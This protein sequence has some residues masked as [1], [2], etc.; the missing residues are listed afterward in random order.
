MN[1]LRIN[2]L[3]EFIFNNILNKFLPPVQDPDVLAIH[4]ESSG[5]L[6]HALIMPFGSF[7]PIP[8]WVAC[9]T[10][11]IL[12][13]RSYEAIES[14][15]DSR[16]NALWIMLG[17]ETFNNMT[18][19]ELTNFESYYAGNYYHNVLMGKLYEVSKL[20]DRPPVKL[21]DGLLI[22]NDTNIIKEALDT[23]GDAI[24]AD[25]FEAIFGTLYVLGSQLQS[26]GLGEEITSLWFRYIITT[27]DI[28]LD[29]TVGNSKSIIVQMF[30]RLNIPKGVTFNKKNN[31]IND[32][33]VSVTGWW[34]LS[35]KAITML[36]T[37]ASKLGT[38]ISQ[39]VR[40]LTPT[41]IL[42]R[43]NETITS[44]TNDIT[45]ELSAKAALDF[46]LDFGVT[47]QWAGSIKTMIDIYAISDDI[48]DTF[49]KR[50]T[51]SGYVSMDLFKNNKYT[52]PT[53]FTVQLNG[54][55][56]TGR[57]DL[58][59][60]MV[61]NKDVPTIKAD[62]IREYAQGSTRQFIV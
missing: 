58:L 1:Q 54:I 38:T 27:C 9:F 13:H 62:I 18:P 33:I 17:Y 16:V 52:T 20:T 49:T 5:Y 40:S 21:E 35:H 36:N 56:A 11:P 44:S 19:S 15:G 10:S 26:K 4:P 43:N 46:L 50:L 42:A 60:T 29:R 34:T 41:T 23:I 25:L 51:Q 61:S 59:M 32:L 30:D 2:Q 22:G 7:D 48:K 3:S 28:Q 8:Y 47:P 57:E 14:I 12:S 24:R 53:H 6:S 39:S 55:T 37:E 31:R 45:K